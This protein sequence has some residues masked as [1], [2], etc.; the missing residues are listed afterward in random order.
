MIERGTSNEHK[1]FLETIYKIKLM[2][3]LLIQCKNDRI[4][5]I[6]YNLG[7]N[8][9]KDVSLMKLMPI[10]YITLGWPIMTRP[11]AKAHVLLIYVGNVVIVSMKAIPSISQYK[12]GC[13]V[14]NSNGK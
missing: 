13:A 12:T 5:R 10:V 6:Y 14:W 4:N 8:L 9:S 11:V 1:L 2:Y 7:S 3:V